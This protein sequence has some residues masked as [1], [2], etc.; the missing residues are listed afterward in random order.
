[1]LKTSYKRYHKKCRFLNGT[2]EKFFIMRITPLLKMTTR[3]L[4]LKH[5]LK[6]LEWPGA[7][8]YNSIV[9]KTYSTDEVLL[10]ILKIF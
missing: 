5:F 7:L 10:Y 2:H 9:F 4:C 3:C 6:N 1:M 8:S